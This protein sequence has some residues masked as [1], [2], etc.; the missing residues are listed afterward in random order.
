M[1]KKWLRWVGTVGAFLFL[2]GMTWIAVL[3]HSDRDYPPVVKY[4]VRLPWTPRLMV[5]F[6]PALLVI[7]G[8]ERGLRYLRQH[9]K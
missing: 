3:N 9:R 1:H 7:V 5:F 2:A 4:E 6:G 8:A